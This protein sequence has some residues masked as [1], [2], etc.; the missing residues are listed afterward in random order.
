MYLT[1]FDPIAFVLDCDKSLQ[2]IYDIISPNLEKE[3]HHTEV[4]G[5]PMPSDAGAC[6]TTVPQ[7]VSVWTL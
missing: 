3:M 2:P 5:P 1:H 6:S 4:V 7:P